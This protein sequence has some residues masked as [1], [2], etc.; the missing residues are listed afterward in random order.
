M[1]IDQSGF[2]ASLGNRNQAFSKYLEAKDYNSLDDIIRAFP[3]LASLRLQSFRITEP[4]HSLVIRSG[5]DDNIHKAIKYGIWTT[6]FKNKNKLE[7]YWYD[8]QSRGTDTYLFF[9][10]VKSGHFEGVARLASGYHEETFPFWWENQHGKFKGHFD[11]EWLYIKDLT[12]RHFEGLKNQEGEDVT[13]SKDCDELSM[14]VTRRMF[15]SYANYSKDKSIFTS[16]PS[17][18]SARRTSC[19]PWSRTSS[20]WSS[21]CGTWSS[22]GS[23]SC[24]SSSC[25]RACRCRP[26]PSSWAA[27][28]SR[29]WP[30]RRRWART[31]WPTTPASR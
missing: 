2:K 13:K 23:T 21:R 7:E 25:S 26:T 17:S 29:S 27:P 14:E 24:S 19:A 5:N 12:Y 11:I 22:C 1:K 8:H 6:T 16:F 10:A 20:R 28:W 31:S 9:S 15:N 4:C 3:H 30:P 18:T